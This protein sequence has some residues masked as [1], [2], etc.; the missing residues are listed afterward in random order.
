MV[1]SALTQKKKKKRSGT[2]GSSV[3]IAVDVLFQEAA[4]RGAP[5]PAF[6][7]VHAGRYEELR[8][9]PN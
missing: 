2:C 7:E 4:R 8:Y 9:R 5:S 6:P 1:V 3:L